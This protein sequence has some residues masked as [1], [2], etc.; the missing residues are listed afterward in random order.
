MKLYL[1]YLLLVF[2]S[3]AA[4]Q[5]PKPKTAPAKAAVTPQPGAQPL[6]TISDTDKLALRDLQV[7]SLQLAS[8]AKDLSAQYG[9]LQQQLVAVNGKINQKV[10]EVFKKAK[11]DQKEYQID[12]K[13]LVFVPKPPPTKK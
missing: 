8:Q 7:E 10:E 12:P 13:T 4:A 3:V 11:L 2:V 1:T 6:P 9:Q 5:A